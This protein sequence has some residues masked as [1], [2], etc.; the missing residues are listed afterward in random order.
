VA[1]TTDESVI[2]TESED[3]KSFTVSENPDYVAAS[4]AAYDPT[5]MS[6][7]EKI[8]LS[9]FG[10]AFAG[11]VGAVGYFS[12]KE[13]KRIE[14]ASAARQAEM[15]RKREERAAWFDTQRKEGRTVVETVDGKFLAIP[16]EAYASAEVRV[17]GI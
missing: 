9:I 10:L 6:K 15:K 17:K 11:F 8:G 13:N 16:N 5:P 1:T 12:H 7:G 4:V 3:G 14:E 2:I